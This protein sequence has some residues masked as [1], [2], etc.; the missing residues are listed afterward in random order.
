MLKVKLKT[1]SRC[2]QADACFSQFYKNKNATLH[3][4]SSLKFIYIVI[5]STII[6]MNYV[7]V[8]N[9]NFFNSKNEN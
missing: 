1:S 4:K 9:D 3:V 6:I 2:R 8:D 5:C 7:H